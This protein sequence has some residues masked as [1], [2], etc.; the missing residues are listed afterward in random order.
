MYY[1]SIGSNLQQRESN[2]DQALTV[3]AQLGNTTVV[4]V[5]PVFETQP[6]ELLEQPAFLNIA[7]KVCSHLEPQPF[8]QELLAIENRLGRERTIRYGPRTIDID[9]LL[10]D[11][12]VVTLAPE[13]LIPHPKMHE[14][15][16]VLLPLAQ[17][18]ANV[19]HPTLCKTVAELCEIVAGKEGV[20]WYPIRLRNGCG[21][22]ES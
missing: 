12:L 18:A 13:L 10:C 15:A 1:L 14:R 16:F 4:D 17:I 3:I 19:L 2:I 11:E 9:I 21:H 7:A 5:S 8:L 22:T 6:V 20:Q